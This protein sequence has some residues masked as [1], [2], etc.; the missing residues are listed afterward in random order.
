MSDMHKWG[1]RFIDL[2]EHVSR[3]S[4]DP[5]T[6]T[7][8]VVVRPDKTVASIGYNGFPAGMKDD[9]ELYN[10]REEKYERI[11]HC[12][13]NAVL[14]A[15]E[16]VKGC[17]LYTYPF[18]SCPRCAVHMIAAGITKVVAPKCPA[19]KLDRWGDALERS[20]A[21]FREAG[22][23]V[24]ETEDGKDEEK[25]YSEGTTRTSLQTEDKEKGAEGTNPDSRN[26]R[27]VRVLT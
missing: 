6:Q 26:K 27:M 8:A 21:L 5:S 3:W 23:I 17:T 19:D 15:H 11:V 22:V 10:N 12:E 14:N 9:E 24:I 25:S 2:A 4:K 16:S 20:K 18:L 7:G 1:Q 13:M